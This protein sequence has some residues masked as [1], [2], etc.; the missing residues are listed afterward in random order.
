MSEKL[1]RAASTIEDLVEQLRWAG[2][3][4]ASSG[5]VQGSGGNLSARLPGA[6][7]C[8]ITASGTW[9]DALE[10]E[11]FSVVS[12]DGRVISGNPQPSSEVKLHLASYLAR[13]DVTAVIHLHPQ[14]S[15]LLAA[16]HRR[17]RFF[18]IDHVYYVRDVAVTP[19]IPSGSDELLKLVRTHWRMPMPSF[20]ATMDAR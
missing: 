13:E 2:E 1:K 16:L 20:L 7:H 4:A 11:D 19:W 9:L 3:K 10:I 18:T 5:L 6:D 17:I 14:T 15:V 8:V 12:L